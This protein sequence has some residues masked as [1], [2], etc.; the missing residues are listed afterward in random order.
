LIN[1][2]PKRAISAIVKDLKGNTWRWA[3]DY[4]S[5]KD[6]YVTWQDGYSAFSVS[7]DRIA[8][9]RNY[10]RYQERHHAHQNLDEEIQKLKQAHS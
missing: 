5:D 8:Q 10:I 2:R 1:H 4:L 6:D 9:V 3:R 7:P